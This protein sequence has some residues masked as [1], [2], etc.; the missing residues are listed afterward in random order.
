MTNTAR[1]SSG[2]LFAS[3]ALAAALPTRAASND[4]AFWRQLQITDGVSIQQTTALPARD[5]AA[6]AAAPLP[7]QEWIIVE[8]QRSEGYVAEPNAGARSRLSN[9][10]G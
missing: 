2:I 6:E 3:L 4:D 5:V 9:R 8:L 7:N 10:K 1:F